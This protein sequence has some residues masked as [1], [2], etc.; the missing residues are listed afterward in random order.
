LTAESNVESMG[1]H[2][3]GRLEGEV[4]RSIRRVTVCAV[5]V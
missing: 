1:L 3:F 2:S 4:M 5:E